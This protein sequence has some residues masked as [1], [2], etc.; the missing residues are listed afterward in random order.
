MMSALIAGERATPGTAVP[1]AP[2]EDGQIGEDD[3]DDDEDDVEDEDDMEADNVEFPGPEIRRGALLCHGSLLQ[4]VIG[5]SRCRVA[6]MTRHCAPP[7]S[8]GGW[9]DSDDDDDD[10]DNVDDED[11][12]EADNVEFSGPEIRRGALLCHGSLLQDAIG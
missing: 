8:R 3:L 7:S 4:D 1:P 12:M 6:P 9:A 10:E 2:G 11:D 5:Y